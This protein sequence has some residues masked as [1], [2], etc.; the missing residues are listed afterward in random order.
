MKWVSK[1]TFIT[2]NAVSLFLLEISFACNPAFY[3]NMGKTTKTYIILLHMF[4]LLQK[5]PNNDLPAI[6]LCLLP[7]TL[8]SNS[9]FMTDSLYLGLIQMNTTI[10]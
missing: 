4:L 1:F 6:I 3:F 9:T 8:L 5:H 10:A 7:T 2:S